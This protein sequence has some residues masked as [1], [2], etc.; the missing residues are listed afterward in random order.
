MWLQ[1]MPVGTSQDYM[2]IQLV[3]QSALQQ[4]L[5]CQSQSLSLQVNSTRGL[6]GL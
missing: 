3:D 5:K 2:Q 1:N 4:G 6:T